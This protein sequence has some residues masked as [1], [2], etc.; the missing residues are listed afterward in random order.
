MARA[1]W[2]VPRDEPHA[3]LDVDPAATPGAPGD[4][5]VTEAS[6]PA[7]LEQLRVLHERLCAEGSR[8]V[9]VVLQG[10]DASGKD[11]TISK[12]LRRLNPLGTRVA[13]FKAPAMRSSATTSSLAGPC[14]LPVPGEIAIFNRSHYVDVLAVGV[15]GLVTEHIWRRRCAHINAFE[16]LLADAGTTVIKI[17][18]HVSKKEQLAR[19]DKRRDD[20]T[21]R[22]KLNDDDLVE[23]A[24]W[25]GVRRRLR[26][27][28]VEH[29]DQG[30]SVDVVP[31]DHK[32]YRD[33][34]VST[35]LVDVLNALD[36]RYPKAP[37]GAPS[38]P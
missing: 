1:R 6:V 18:L 8:S 20:P 26:R 21:E 27:D 36:P 9:L 12:V 35:I 22:W 14:P 31:A 3:P 23:R 16:A 28:A 33:W 32:W 37:P 10:V 4:R 7:L 30:R 19:L 11:G 5:L 13:A 38:R 25:G 2:Q 15:H 34:A 29:L 17:L 24:F